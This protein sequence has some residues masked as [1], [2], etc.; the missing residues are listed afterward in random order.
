VSPDLDLSPYRWVPAY[1]EAGQQ[2]LI[3][4]LDRS[5]VLLCSLAPVRGL[6]LLSRA[7]FRSPPEEDLTKENLYFT[8]ADRGR[9]GIDIW[10]GGLLAEPVSSISYTFPNGEVAHA[11][12]GEQSW[13]LSYHSDH[14]FLDGRPLNRLPPVEVDVVLPSGQT[15]HYTIPFRPDSACAQLRGLADEV[16][17][18]C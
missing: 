18:L 11:V 2:L 13:I 7:K 17:E 5:D 16:N 9:R 10:T 14:P 1:D 8:L 3:C 15:Q 6:R 12:I 4:T